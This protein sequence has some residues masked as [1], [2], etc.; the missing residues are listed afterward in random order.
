VIGIVSIT[1]TQLFEKEPRGAVYVPF[2]QGFTSNAFFHVRPSGSP[3]GLVEAV[4]REVRAAAPGLPL[5]S[6]RTFAT[7]LSGAAEYWALRLSTAMFAFFGGLALI[8]ALVGIYG[9]TAYAVARRTKEIG[10]R[11][12][13]GARPG[14]VFRMI[15]N[16]SLATA[17]AGIAAGWLLGLGIGQVMASTFVDLAAFDPWTFSFVPVVFVLAALAATWMPARRATEVN[18]VTALRTE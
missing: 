3:E 15:L 1:Q 9:V 4:R 17:V 14:A 7:H 12:A 2:A 13:I 8:V 18:P 16:E 10:V 6:V 11:M 5:F